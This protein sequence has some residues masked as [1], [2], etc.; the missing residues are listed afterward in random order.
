MLWKRG[1][2]AKP[3]GEAEATDGKARSAADELRAA[4]DDLA[5]TP[6]KDLGKRR[7]VDDYREFFVDGGENNPLSQALS[8][9][10]QDAYDRRERL[11]PE[12][13]K[14]VPLREDRDATTPQRLADKMTGELKRDMKESGL[15][16][17]THYYSASERKETG[18]VDRTYEVSPKPRK[19]GKSRR[20]G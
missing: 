9:L 8:D 3:K 14:T 12:Q 7:H 6:S 11:L 19:G 5:V 18:E 20:R 17:S 16:P 13:P 4:L 15:A 10:T 2:G 1:R